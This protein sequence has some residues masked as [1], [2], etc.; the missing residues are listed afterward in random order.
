MAGKLT[1]Q[2]VLRSATEPQVAQLP[3]GRVLVRHR[4]G[5]LLL[6]GTSK[7]AVLRV[8]ERVD[9]QSDASTLC[10][11][12]ANELPPKETRR[13]LRALWGQVLLPVQVAEAPALD[14]TVWGHTATAVELARHLG[15]PAPLDPRRPPARDLASPLWLILGEDLPLAILLD[16]QRRA[17]ATGTAALFATADADGDRLGPSALPGTSPCLGCAQLAGLAFLGGPPGERLRAAGQFHTAS[18]HDASAVVHHLAAEA[19]RLLAENAPAPQLVDRLLLFTPGA[20]PRPF[21]L[22]PHPACP[23]CSQTSAVDTLPGAR[24]AEH[25]RMEVEA[26]APRRGHSTD[27][28]IRRVGIVGG[29]TAGY[30]AALALRRRRPELEITLIE[31]SRIPVIG[32]GEATTPLMP[33]FLHVDLGLDVHDFFRRVQPTFKLGIHFQWGPKPEHH[34]SYPFGPSRT[35]EAITHD[36][37]LRHASLRSLLM[38][39]GVL[40]P[41]HLTTETAYHLEN[42]R[43]VHYLEAQARA[44]GTQVVDATLTRVETND[45]GV[46]ALIAEDGRRFTFDLYL[47]CTGFRSLLLGDALGS[48]FES[49]EASLF[50]DRAWVAAMPHGGRILPHTVAEAMH[51]G[52]CWNTPQPEE[53]H[54]GYVFSSA[55]LSDDEALDE[56]RRRNPK[57]G[58]ARLVRFRP[59][60]RQHFQSRNV[61]A[62]GNAYGF[63]E[64]LESTALHLLIRQIGLL[65]DA[66]PRHP[67]DDALAPLLNRRVAGWWDYLRWFLALHFRF[68][69]GYD[70][71]FWRHCRNAVDVSAF[72]ELLELF[73]HRGPLAYDSAL[74]TT[75]DVPDPLWGPEG[76]DVILLGQGVPYGPTLPNLDATAWHA[77]VSRRQRAAQAGR[78][79]AELLQALADNPI[80]LERFVEAFRR[81]GPAF[82]PP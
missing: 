52:W 33:Q 2:T 31:S 64:P 7:D 4:R 40:T 60:R 51:A 26:N 45:E 32:V 29:G 73:K 1:P 25:R 57:M 55:F 13:I 6:E 3:D 12:L 82:P 58:E 66:F 23:L 21:P 75:F 76:I 19:H 34:F 71:P 27:E 68:H 43:F 18:F 67:G 14:V 46:T 80:H 38:E 65:L 9:G 42:R 36:G 81:S 63:V 53:D 24:R 28:P 77:Q 47:D 37:H 11:Q 61:F 50:T 16:L 62:L 10:D 70:T 8:L 22:P 69:R 56:L 44:L 30:L 78:P 48:P 17:L 74:A 15:A 41:D 5:V 79:Q 54:R 72:A 59:G 20:P 39:Q 35:L 49:F